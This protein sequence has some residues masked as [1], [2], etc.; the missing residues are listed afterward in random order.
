MNLFSRP[1][2]IKFNQPIMLAHYCS[3]ACL[4]ES[5]F[6]DDAKEIQKISG[7]CG[8]GIGEFSFHPKSSS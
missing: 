1:I 5:D 4:A 7:V 8:I 6:A 3:G 2:E